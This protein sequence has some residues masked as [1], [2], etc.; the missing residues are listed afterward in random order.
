M[1]LVVANRHLRQET[2]DQGQFL[3]QT[4]QLRGIRDNLVRLIA[5]GA[6]EENDLALRDLLMSNGYHVEAANPSVG[7]P[8]GP[9]VASSPGPA[10][11]PTPAPA[12]S[13][14]K[15]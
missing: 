7:A 6:L 10:T 2:I 4:A 14:T 15:R 1:A 9:P 11:A 12:S 13:S 8:L 3:Q 5:R